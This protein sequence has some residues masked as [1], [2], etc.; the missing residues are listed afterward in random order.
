MA[1]PAFQQWSE[2]YEVAPREPMSSPLLKAGE[3]E[4]AVL[5]SKPCPR[6][7][8]VRHH[9]VFSCERR[10]LAAV[11]APEPSG[12]ASHLGAL[13]LVVAFGQEFGDAL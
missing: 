13:V 3:A 8:F 4:H 9:V 10:M 12:P 5:G 6:P 11:H 7:Q 1:Q 2:S